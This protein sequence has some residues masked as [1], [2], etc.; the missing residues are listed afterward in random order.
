MNCP[1]C[2]KEITNCTNL[3][4]NPQLNIN[5]GCQPAWQGT[6]VITANGANALPAQT[7]AL[8]NINCAAGCAI[9]ATRFQ[10]TYT[11][12]GHS[13]D[14]EGIEFSDKWIV[15]QHCP[16]DVLEGKREFYNLDRMEYELN[17]FGETSINWL[18]E[19]K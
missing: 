12:E 17:E 9:P 3:L 1:H 19:V 16:D 8:N 6:L 13:M 10:L 18:D 15:L 7:L 11:R 14:T 5:N 2:G 4:V